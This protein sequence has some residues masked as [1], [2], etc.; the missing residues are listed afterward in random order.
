MEI[1]I[2]NIAEEKGKEIAKAIMKK[3]DEYSYSYETSKVEKEIYER[4]LHE[5]TAFF[6]NHGDAKFDDKI[7]E[8]LKFRLKIRLQNPKDV[9]KAT[10]EEMFA[11]VIKIYVIDFLL[12]WDGIVI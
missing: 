4:S 7:I 6:L 3:Y 9:K 5:A 12:E 8:T 11:N 1:D 2:E 10:P